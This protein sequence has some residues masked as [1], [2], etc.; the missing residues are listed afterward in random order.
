MK[1][2]NIFSIFFSHSFFIELFFVVIYA[3]LSTLAADDAGGLFQI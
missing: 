1:P 2:L 3:A